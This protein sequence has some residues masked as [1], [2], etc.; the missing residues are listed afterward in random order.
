MYPLS[1]NVGSGPI[2]LIQRD[3]L[4]KVLAAEGWPL[5]ITSQTP[6]STGV[7]SRS[8]YCVPQVVQMKIRE[9]LS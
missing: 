4:D 2:I 9:T 7:W 6:Q 5:P 8:A 3:E 1:G